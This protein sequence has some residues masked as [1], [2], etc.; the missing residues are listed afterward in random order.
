MVPTKPYRPTDSALAEVPKNELAFRWSAGLL[1]CLI[2]PGLG[3][4]PPANSR[5]LG[6]AQDLASF[7]QAHARE[8]SQLH[9][10]R[11]LRRMLAGSLQGIVHGQRLIVLHRGS[12]LDFINIKSLPVAAMTPRLLAPGAVDENAPNRF[13]RGTK[14]VRAVFP[15]W[16]FITAKTRP[17]FVDEGGRLPHPSAYS[18]SLS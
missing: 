10:F 6:N 15:G 11:L 18:P 8:I 7:L 5:G 14:E 2:K 4:R 16:L 9:Q 17:G 3:I 12:N 13:R 1:D